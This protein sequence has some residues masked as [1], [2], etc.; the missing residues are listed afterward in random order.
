MTRSIVVLAA[1]AALLALPATAEAKRGDGKIGLAGLRFDS[2]DPAYRSPV[3]A[4]PAGTPVRMRLR[5]YA[6][7]ITSVRLRVYDVDSAHESF[8]PMRRLSAQVRC[9]KR[10]CE[11]WQATLPNT[12]PANLWYRFVVRDG[13]RTAYYEDDTAALDGGLGNSYLASSDLSWALTVYEP[14]FTT[15]SWTK[16]AVVYQI[17]PDRFRNG[18][19]ANDPR[20]GDPRYDDPV[21]AQ[22]WNALPEGFC[23]GYST[24]GC[25]QQPRGRD[26]QGG[27]LQGVTQ[28]LD[29]L[30]SLGVTA[31]YLNPIF[32]AR[33]NHRYDTADYRNVD[34][35]LG[36]NAAFDALVSAARARGIHVILD[37]VF[38]HMSSDSPFFDRYG[39]YPGL[40]GCESASSPYRSWFLFS[41]S[42]PCAGN[43]YTG[44]AN[45]DSIP[46]LAK[47]NP[48]VQS[49]F[50]D[51]ADSIARTWI[52]RGAAGWRLDVMG[53]PSFPSGWWPSFRRVVKEAS[54]DAVI[55]GELWQKDTT[56]LRQLRGDRADSTMNYR[57]RD[58]VLGLLAPGDFEAKGFPASGSPI[59]PSQFASRVSSIYEDYPRPAWDALMN[60]I[61]SHDTARALWTLTP[62]ADS[63]VAKER[64]AA[65]VAAGKARLRLAA[66]IQ[67]T[68]PGMPTVYYGD[69]AGVTGHED[70]DDR[71]TYPWTDTGGTPDD[72][73]IGTYRSLAALRS[74]VPALQSGDLRF[75]LTGDGAGTVAYVRQA[76]G[77]VALVILNRSA[78]ERTVSVP[79]K[80]L[81]ADGAQLES[82][83]GG[84]G[85]VSPAS[86][87]VHVTVGPL[88]GAVYAGPAK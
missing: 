25:T 47:S 71:R 21:L 36:G 26:Y 39:R 78:V 33:S 8:L 3:G 48:A 43:T 19:A 34:P 11:L 10:K 32:T 73:L 51:S 20:T 76:E 80:G 67:F 58:A 84:A 35:Q 37:G 28:K 55:V 69:E 59:R 49:Y 29:Y 40:G 23:R 85:S 88:A 54:P 50:V 9:G 56:L 72:A 61:D 79:V 68:L 15:P 83:Y 82:R 66:L 86:G 45:F 52:Q 6:K 2:R 81:V 64:N 18:D 53:D 41:G 63:P 44:W 30:Q 24:G 75:L 7:D 77:R 13:R 12:R 27:D 22:P 14:G 31:I 16:S 4:V 62:G 46:V 65:N 17:F 57:L 1:L 38:N 42:G 5:A 74:A 70:P 87:V 60:L